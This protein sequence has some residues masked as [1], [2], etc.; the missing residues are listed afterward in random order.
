M[1]EIHNDGAK[2]PD[3]GAKPAQT[4]LL[5]AGLALVAIVAVLYAGYALVFK[6]G[7][8]DDLKPLAKGEMAK[9]EVPAKLVP[10]PPIVAQGPNGE[11]VRL[12]DLKGQVVVVNLWASW[13]APCI[14]E[15]P[16]LAKLQNAYAGKSV[17]VL[18]IS[19]DKGQ[20]DIDKAKAF[21]ADKQPLLFYHG[22]YSLAF[23]VDPPTE[24]LPTTI[25]Y[26]RTGRERARLSGGA[27][28]STPEAH[29]VLDRLL[30]AKG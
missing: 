3:A 23:A 12:A 10:S 2:A 21:I 25:L 8:S 6:S 5:W 28:W 9:L 15:M 17:K 30:A 11:T 26:D 20:P 29:A 7:Q 24:G 14:K 18:A 27:D 19:L 13:C 22:E 4:K 1:S 16:S